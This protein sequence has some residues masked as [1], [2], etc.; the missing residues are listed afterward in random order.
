MQIELLG[1]ELERVA[2]RARD[3]DGADRLPQVRDV[4]LEHGLG[5]AGDLLAPE[6]VDQSCGRHHL[7]DVEGENR[8]YGALLRPPERERAPVH[9]YVERAEDPDVE[10]HLGRTL[11]R[12]PSGFMAAT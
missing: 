4:A 1:L 11:A 10:R 5:A 9:L 7:T 3:E 12:P 8:Q 6:L 2:G